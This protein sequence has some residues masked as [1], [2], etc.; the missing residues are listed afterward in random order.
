MIPILVAALW[1][2]RT[3][4]PVA[5][6]AAETLPS[7]SYQLARAHELEPHRRTIPLVGVPSGSHQLRLKLVVSSTGSVS[8]ADGQGD[9][10]ALKFWPAVRDEVSRWR[11]TP[12]EKAGRPVA[13]EVEEYIDLVPPERLPLRHVQAPVIRP[14]SK[15]TISLERAACYGTCPDYTVAVSTS[16]IV[17]EGRGFVVAQGKHTAS[18]DSDKVR[19]LAKRFVEADFYSMDPAYRA[20]VTDCP[21]YRLTI[22]I[23]GQT[24]SVTDYM[25]SWEGMPAVITDLEGRTDSLAHTERWVE[26]AEG[27]VQALLD[28]RFNFQTFDAQMMLKEAASRG[29]TMTVRGLLEAGVPLKLLPAPT[30]KESDIINPLEF[31][32]WLTAASRHPDTVAVLIHA[33]ASRTDQRDKDLALAGAAESGRLDA[34]RALIAY[35]AN[36]NADLDSLQITR[37]IA[38]ITW[39]DPYSGSVLIYAAES[40]NPEMIREILRYRPNLEARNRE[41]KTAIFAAGASDSD[42]RDGARVECVRLLAKA[43]ADVNAR[44]KE[45]QTPIFTVDDSVLSL[46]IRYGANLNIRNNKG[47]TVLDAARKTSPQRVEALRDAMQNVHTPK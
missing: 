40:G 39:Q 23:D 16:G 38:G 17:F 9:N 42:D 12:F 30:A 14:D 5:A 27:L 24:K 31:S 46:L 18:I 7:F 13:A 3:G 2:P 34:V 1:L 4:A 29:Q 20:L 43:G 36:P 44:D 33:G 32:G 25:G 22:A 11:F 15:V 8:K 37:H 41:G 19:S 6:Q 47:E 26:G 21:T 35:G 28:E 45:G 10:D